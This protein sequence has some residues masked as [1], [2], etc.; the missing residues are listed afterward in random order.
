MKILIIDDSSDYR[1]LVKLY[2]SKELSDVEIV[3]Y[4]FDQLGKP[5]DNFDWSEYDVL[6]L[7]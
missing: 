3:Q 1:A 5:A 7:N 2:L 4:D 6:L